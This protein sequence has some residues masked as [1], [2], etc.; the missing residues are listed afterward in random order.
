MEI[1]TVTSA[2]D[3]N[4]AVIKNK[5][6]DIFISSAAVGDFSPVKSPQKMKKE[7]QPP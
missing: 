7:R 3:M 6:C 5:D 4:K 1:D 2:S